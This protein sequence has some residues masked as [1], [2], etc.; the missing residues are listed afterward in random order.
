MDLDDLRVLGIELSSDTN[1][2]DIGAINDLIIA[3]G[4][5]TLSDLQ[6]AVTVIEKLNSGELNNNSALTA[7]DPVI[8]FRGFDNLHLLK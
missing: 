5:I 8:S 4:D 1:K 2:A 6:A 7:S 3:R